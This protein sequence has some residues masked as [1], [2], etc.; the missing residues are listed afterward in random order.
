MLSVDKGANSQQFTH[1]EG[2]DEVR[3]INFPRIK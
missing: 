2:T 3:E 1:E